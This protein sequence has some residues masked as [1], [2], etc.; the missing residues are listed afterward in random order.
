MSIFILLTSENNVV[1]TL[2]SDVYNN[3]FEGTEIS[4]EKYVY[5][6]RKDIIDCTY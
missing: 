6:Q 3:C 1:D 5:Q 2:K 4:L